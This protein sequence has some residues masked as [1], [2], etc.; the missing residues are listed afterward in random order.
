M[1]TIRALRD[2]ADPRQRLSPA[3][4]T[5]SDSSPLRLPRW[6][7]VLIVLV[8]ALEIIAA[9]AAKSYGVDAPTHMYWSSR[10]FEMLQSGEFIP[11]WS[12]QGFQGYGSPAFYFYPPLYFYFTSAIRF[13]FGLADPLRLLQLSGLLLTIACFFSSRYFLR[14]IGADKYPATIGAFLYAFAPFR[15]AE[16]YSRT[17]LPAHLGYV[18]LPILW[19]GLYQ[20]FSPQTE[21]R[22]ILLAGASLAL[23]FLST[24][25]LTIGTVGIIGLLCIVE[26]KR[27]TARIARNLALAALL[28][29]G[30]IAYQ[31]ASILE[32][33]SHVHL[34]ALTRVPDFLFLHMMNLTMLP[35]VYHF[36]LIYLPGVMLVLVYLFRGRFSEQLTQREVTVLRLSVTVFAIFIFLDLPIVSVPIWPYISVLVQGT[37]RSYIYFLMIPAV[38]TAVATTATMRKSVTF[39]VALWSL[40]AILPLVLILADIHFYSHDAGR[41]GDTNEYLPKDASISIVQSE[42]VQT[43]VSSNQPVIVSSVQ[44][45]VG[46]TT[47]FHQFYWP[48]WHLYV[49]GMEI[50][51]RPD[52]VGCA[53]ATLR[54]VATHLHWE[55]EQTPLERAGLWISGLTILGIASTLGIGLVRHG[56]LRSR[57]TSNT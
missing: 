10:F 13:V 56:V 31:V 19:C 43:K 21:R 4:Q 34:A 7:V 11:R 35:A 57:P 51:T 47:T 26:R 42:P 40:G 44:S 28:C 37:W 39:I 12:P 2:K 49:G 5:T 18:F 54:N 36:V 22:G 50:P 17:S 32:Y 27:L 6:L 41:T 52:S 9:F 3:S 15:L 1:T 16:L 55:L 25:P 48:A 24:I 14:V 8:V 23:L 29:I 45:P 53:V 20:L 38:A 33:R 46:I 30:L